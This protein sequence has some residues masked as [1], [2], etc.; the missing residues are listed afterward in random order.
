MKCINPTLAYINADHKRIFRSFDLA[1]EIVKRNSV[2]FNCG[3]CLSC[4]KRNSLELARRC[5]LHASNYTHN[6]FLTLTYN[7]SNLGDNNINYSD[8]QKFKKRLR[9]Y[10]EKNYHKK[11]EI[12][13]VHEYGKNGRKHW[14]LVV[15]NF[16]FEDKTLFTT[17]NSIPIYTSQ[18]LEKLWPYGYN[19]IGSVTEASALYQA[20]YTQKDIKNGNTNNSKK[21]KSNH[22]GIGKPYFLKNFKQILSLGYIPFDGKKMPVPRYFE[23]IAHKHYCHYY[24][25][26]AF[27]DLPYRKKLYTP[28]KQGDEKK[29]IA[30]LYLY[31]KEQKQI[32]IKEM[33]ENWDEEMLI[34]TETKNKPDFV[35][36]GEN[37]IYE[38]KKRNETSQEEF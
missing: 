31:Y 21:S 22:S 28:F 1:T 3:K 35:L 8:I 36:S 26:S 7:E 25:H 32:H 37:A 20:Q 23:K 10:V 24:D 27:H 12:F 29:E 5:V 33:E 16:D 4:R 34:H 19:T 9:K 13:N 18:L 17:K 14:H 2:P 6:C 15:F 38:F 30:D 11:I